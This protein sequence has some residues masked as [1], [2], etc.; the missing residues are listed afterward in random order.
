M[1]GVTLGALAVRTTSPLLLITHPCASTIL[2]IVLTLVG[3]VEGAAP[4]RFSTSG[5][6]VAQFVSTASPV[7]VSPGL[8]GKPG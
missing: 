5:S 2:V 4:E 7:S 8:G 3:L 1:L 6:S